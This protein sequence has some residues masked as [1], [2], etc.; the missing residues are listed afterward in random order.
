MVVFNLLQTLFQTEI[1]GNFY[2]YKPMLEMLIFVGIGLI[3]YRL[4][5]LTNFNLVRL[6]KLGLIII[7]VI[8]S[9]LLLIEIFNQHSDFFLKIL[10]II[11]IAPTTIIGVLLLF[12]VFDSSPLKYKGLFVGLY[13]TLITISHYISNPLFDKFMDNRVSGLIISLIIVSGIFVFLRDKKIKNNA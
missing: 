7:I 13:Y 12:L 9:I 10:Q 6:I 4:K 2:P 1:T 5:K 8:I 11:K 3:L